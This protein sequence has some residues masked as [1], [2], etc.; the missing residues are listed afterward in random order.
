MREL[1]G[2][3]DL[4]LLNQINELRGKLWMGIRLVKFVLF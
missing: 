4:E 2:A 3:Y 1:S